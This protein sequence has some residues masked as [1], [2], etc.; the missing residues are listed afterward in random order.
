MTDISVCLADPASRYEKTYGLMLLST[1]ELNNPLVQG[2]NNQSQQ[3]GVV[4]ASVST[5][6]SKRE[7]YFNL[8]K[9]ISVAAQ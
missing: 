2:Q 1:N 3:R 7:G 5:F 6:Y 9:V 4:T 8:A